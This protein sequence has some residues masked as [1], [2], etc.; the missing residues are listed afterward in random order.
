MSSV[1]ADPGYFLFSKIIKHL[2]GEQGALRAASWICHYVE[3]KS[4]RTKANLKYTNIL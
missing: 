3:M 2:V 1:G 4:R